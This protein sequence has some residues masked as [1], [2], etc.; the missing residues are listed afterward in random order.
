MKVL[1][2][3]VESVIRRMRWKAF[4]YLNDGKDKDE[5]GSE[6]HYG[7]KSKRSPPHVDELDAFEEDLT[8]LIEDVQFRKTC[9]RFQNTLQKDIQRIK[10]SKAVL[11]PA[12]KT[13]NLYELGKDQYEK[14]LTE[15]ITKHYRTADK[16]AYNGVNEEAQVIAKE[17]DIA[18]RMETMAKREAYI[19]LKDHKD[20]FEN[21]LP[22]R[23][24]NPAKSE[25]GMVSK[26]MLDNINGRLKKKLDVT[27]WNNSAAVI[28]WF[29]SIKDKDRCTFM[30]FDVVEFYPS[31]SESLLEKALNFAKQHIEI[32]DKEVKVI[33]HSR[34]SL[35]FSK[36]RAWMKKGGDGLFDVTMGSYD[37]AEV[38]EL[39][40]MFA[41]S[42]LPDRYQKENIGLYRDDGLGVVRDMSGCETERMRKDVTKHFKNLGLRITIETNMKITNF[43]D[44]T[45]NLANGKYYPYRKPNDIPLYIHR[46]SNHP[47]S[48]LSHLPAAISRR[49]TDISNDKDVFEAAA[50][51]YNNALSS[52][53]YS[54]DVRYIEER[55]M[56]Q[57]RNQ[58]RKRNRARKVTWFN[59]PY[60]KSV[61]LNIGQKF[62][63]LLDKHFPAGSRLHKIFNRNTVKVSYCCMPNMSAIIKRHN[64]HVCDTTHAGANQARHCNCRKPEECPLSR[65][66]LASNIVYR[67]TVSTIGTATQMYYIGSTATTFKQRYA[68]HKASFTHEG[69]ANQ[70]AL[71]K[72]VWQLKRENVAYRVDWKIVQRA[73]AYSNK[74]KRCDLCLM[75]KL[76]ILTA[77]KTTLLNKRSEIVSKCRHQQKFSLS[78][79]ACAPT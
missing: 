18:D 66:C 9:D 71:S 12:D 36:D 40:G 62:L 72:Y 1:I 8:T 77:E 21:S 33:A 70:T 76:M 54:D 37:G 38:C 73:A 22:C 63:R 30:C 41:L 5:D 75:E 43:L 34:K 55:K 47:P 46:L 79:F 59:P 6:D 11:V 27:I 39:V 58:P 64:A 28:E 23:L 65:E 2:E 31:I 19:T 56:G 25:M 29:Q 45:L 52:S 78:S 13:R 57:R 48:I 24:I 74:S 61:K 53:G 4:F 14:L 17:L 16:D 35:L 20:N 15:N 42:Q 26:H 44:L 67:A 49:L 69:K 7:L 32:S 3:K 10:S 51:I 50:P 60:S 68:N